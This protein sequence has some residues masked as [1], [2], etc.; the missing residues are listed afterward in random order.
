MEMSATAVTIRVANF[1][2]GAEIDE[3]LDSVKHA[4]RQH[5]LQQLKLAGA[6]RGYASIAAGLFEWF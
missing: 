5:S 6:T 3:D 4:T 2:T 1:I